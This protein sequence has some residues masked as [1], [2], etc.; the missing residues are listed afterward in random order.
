MGQEQE[1]PLSLRYGSFLHVPAVRCV[2][3]RTDPRFGP[4]NLQER[5]FKSTVGMVERPETNSCTSSLLR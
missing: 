2:G 4:A 5:K 1:P 3:P